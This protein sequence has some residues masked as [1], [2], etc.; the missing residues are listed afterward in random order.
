MNPQR[1][2]A[3]FVALG[4]G[5]A[6]TACT[7]Q[8]SSPT[9]TPTPT[10]A[11][12]VVKA[13]EP[14]I[15]FQSSNTCLF[16]GPDPSSVCFQRVDGSVRHRVVDMGGELLHP[17]WS[18]DGSHIAYSAAGMQIWTAAVDGS[19]AKMIA[20]CSRFAGC[21]GLDF[22]AWSPD[23]KSLAF[24]V[25]DGS[26]L[27]LGPPTKD[28]LAIVDL[29]SGTATPFA[30]TQPY[31][32]VDQPRWSPDGTRLAVQV[33]QFDAKGNELGST[34][35]IVTVADGSRKLLTPFSTFATYPDWNPKSDRIVFVTNDLNPAG[36]RVGLDMIDA[37]G[38]NLAVIEY[39]GSDAQQSKQPAWTP[40]GSKVIFVQWQSHEL[41]EI[42]ADGSGFKKLG[43]TGTHPRLRP[44]P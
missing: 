11:S 32:L 9:A 19:G 8:G 18:P 42:N 13:G 5:L 44:I 39:P 37:D 1:L 29:A 24:T 2:L 34:I 35:G 20:D 21:N 43:G 6:L 28:E 30:Q 36:G 23:G 14:W 40:D 41:A 7:A 10:A 4:F 17:D 15:L 31:E 16:G 3:V 26:P 22:P 38:S 33:E 12:T 25:Y 27:P